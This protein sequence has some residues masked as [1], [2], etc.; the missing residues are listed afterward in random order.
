MKARI[1]G[2]LCV[3]LLVAGGVGWSVR[4]RSSAPGAPETAT[5]STSPSP[6][7]SASPSASPSS[8]AASLKGKPV[9]DCAPDRPSGS[10]APTFWG[11]HVTTPVG[12]DFPD[13]PIGAINL[14][15]SQA[16][17][18]QM[19]TAPG[20]YD[21]SHLDDIVATASA[22]HARPMLLLGL[23]PSF[24]TAHP[25]SPT[26]RSTMPDLGAWRSWVTAVVD[27]Y[28]A[29]L[30][31]QVWPE[32]N[33]PG[34]WSGTPRQM[35]RLSVIAGDL[36]HEHAPRALVV[37]PA[38][39]LR[40]EGQ[41]SWMDRFWSTKVGGQPVADSMDV[42]TV[43]PFPLQDGTPEDSLDLV[44]Q[45]RSILERDGVALPVWTNEI[46]Y[47][48]PSGGNAT[49]VQHYPDSQQAAFLARTY[50]LDAAAGVDRVYWLGWASYA[51][52]AVEL[53]R[54]GAETPAATAFR[55]VH[56]W[57]GTGPH[58]ECRVLRRVYTCQVTR[59][60]ERVTIYWRPRGSSFVRAPQGITHLESIAGRRRP[61]GAGDRFRVGPAPV[62]ALGTPSS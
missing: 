17:W 13:A 21:F 26:A 23:S 19:E 39:A 62:A 48:V 5:T 34:N 47:G 8:H 61:A 57:L 29:R 36:I 52:M 51:G 49:G 43:D 2:T 59:G 33:I 41:R 15:T 50:L 40:L 28:G 14:T 25:E 3:V 1:V 31:Y 6:S 32:P 24:H 22:R 11:M 60:D 42:V 16:Y 9:A 18:Y 56:E 27:R 10:L 53:V 45:A 55:T 35:A 12:D 38:T 37:A 46:N 20:S 58:P 4:T 54:D 30:D 44:C 7:D